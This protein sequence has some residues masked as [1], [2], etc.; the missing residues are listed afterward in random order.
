MR[1]LTVS[2]VVMFLLAAAPQAVADTI[3]PTATEGTVTQNSV[4]GSFTT[5]IGPGGILFHIVGG[6]GV[7]IPATPT[8]PVTIEMFDSISENL[9]AGM[10]TLNISTL[11][12]YFSYTDSSNNPV[13]PPSNGA[14]TVGKFQATA[15]LFL[16]A[17]PNTDTL[18]LLHLVPTQNPTVVAGF[19][20]TSTTYSE[21]FDSSSTPGPT[22]SLSNEQTA[23]GTYSA[24][25]SQF[26]VPVTQAY[27]LTI[28]LVIQISNLATDGKE[29]V[30]FDLPLD[31]ET[32]PV[33][34]PANLS[35][36]AI[37]AIG[38]LGYA[39]RRRSARLA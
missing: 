31:V 33:P 3:T 7:K 19:A 17:P 18:G 10:T 34:E 22:S 23:G 35:I 2:F 32:D 30:Y 15:T 8:N 28:D 26:L 29:T 25:S 4:N 12:G 21:T 27:T 9:T 14:P 1:R 20:S 5:P 36:L 24:H 39:Y 38:M 13:I 6:A 16:T 11:A 37:G